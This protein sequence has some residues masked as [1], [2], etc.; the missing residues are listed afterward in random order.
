MTIE[1]TQLKAIAT[2]L[3]IPMV[4]AGGVFALRARADDAQTTDTVIVPEAS[5]VD[6]ATPVAPVL[7][8]IVLEAP[9]VPATPVEVAT[10]TPVE[11][12]SPSATDTVNIVTAS[13]TATAIVTDATMTPTVTTEAPIAPVLTGLTLVSGWNLIGWTDLTETSAAAIEA[14]NPGVDTVS[15]FNS[16]TQLLEKHDGKVSLQDFIIKSGDGLLIHKI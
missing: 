2:L 4:M 14:A 10:T 13:A 12:V 11:S 1:K 7:T 16:V 5:V 9:A 15:K 8:D 3:L 6:P